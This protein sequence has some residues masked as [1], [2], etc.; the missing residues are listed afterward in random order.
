MVK[1]SQI[2]LQ[3][4][5]FIELFE[6]PSQFL[7]IKEFNEITKVFPK[8]TLLHLGGRRTERVFISIGLHGNE[9]AGFIAVQKLLRKYLNSQ[10]PRSI[11]IF[12]G[13]VLAAEKGLR[14][15]DSQ[16]DFNRVWPGTL[17]ADC[18]EKNMMAQITQKLAAHSLFAS[19][20]VHNNTGKNPHYAC[21]N[22]LDFQSLQL[23]RLF[24]NKIVFFQNP[25][26]VQSAAF[27]QFCPSVALE[28]GKA[29]NA[30]GGEHAFEFVDAVLHAHSIPNHELKPHEAGVFQTIARVCI[31]EKYSFGFDENDCDIN[32]LHEIENYNFS[33]LEI[34]AVFG[35]TKIGAN[36]IALDDEN[37]DVTSQFFSNK[38]GEIVLKR[39][40]MPAML[41]LDK[42]VIRQDCLCY[43][44]SKII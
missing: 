41:T 30:A 2:G 23:A 40:L 3:M 35:H 7:E 10:L 25:K 21:V 29:G 37:Y 26:G 18:P 15:L 13:N 39:A 5:D 14:V 28:C 8:P 34:G 42:R 4:S 31:P 44:M 16:N 1:K 43:L 27:A 36:L 24:S 38:T 33:E 17:I 9:D 20:D 19:I 6:L 11:S 32:L 12:F 22:V